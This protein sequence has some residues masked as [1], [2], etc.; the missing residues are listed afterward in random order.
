M[1]NAQPKQPIPDEVN[2]V[3][4]I[5]VQDQGRTWEVLRNGPKSWSLAPGSQGMLHDLAMEEMAHRLGELG[6]AYWVEEGDANPARYGF[7]SDDYRLTVVLR[8]GR[9]LKV[10]IG[11]T[12]PSGYPF[13]TVD[14]DG[15]P[16]VFEFPWALYQ[17][18]QLYLT[19]PPSP[20]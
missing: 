9:Q 19:P 2:D 18:V 13:A 11:G 16:W 14:L 5:V 8:D 1:L 15:R 12:A 20:R 6:A 3:A 4:R 10:E 17:F 7:N